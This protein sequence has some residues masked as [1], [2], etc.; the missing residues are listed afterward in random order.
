[1]RC[2]WLRRRSWNAPSWPRRS[3]SWNRRRA[4]AADPGG[5]TS[6]RGRKLRIHPSAVEERPEPPGLI[7]KDVVDALNQVSS[8]LDGE[9]SHR[10]VSED[11]FEQFVAERTGPGSDADLRAG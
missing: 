11:R 4:R 6:R 8:G 5:L 10:L 9:V 3:W 7:G 2:P 1:M